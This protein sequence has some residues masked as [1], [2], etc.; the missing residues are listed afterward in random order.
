VQIHPGFQIAEVQA[1]G[2]ETNAPVVFSLHLTRCEAPAPGLNAKCYFQGDF[3]LSDSQIAELVTE[4]WYVSAF[5]P[6]IPPIVLRGQII[7]VPE[8]SILSLIALGIGVAYSWLCASRLEKPWNEKLRQK[9]RSKTLAMKTAIRRSVACL[10]LQCVVVTLAART[11]LPVQ[12]RPR[13]ILTNNYPVYAKDKSL[14]PSSPVPLPHSQRLQQTLLP[15]WAFQ[16]VI[17]PILTAPSAR[18]C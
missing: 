12:L 11:N 13:T 7:Q 17:H 4:Q 1:P 15:C 2:L 9:N 6:S 16:P 8:A 3:T 14:T 10:L 5:S 18:T